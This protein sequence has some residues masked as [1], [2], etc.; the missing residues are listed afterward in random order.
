MNP[1]KYQEVW[2]ILAS[3]GYPPPWNTSINTIR[4]GIPKEN[5]FLRTTLRDII[6]PE[7][8][9]HHFLPK[10]CQISV[11]ITLGHHLQSRHQTRGL[12]SLMAA[13]WDIS[14][15]I[16]SVASCYF[17][18]LRHP[19]ASSGPSGADL[20]KYEDIEET[21]PFLF[22]CLIL[23]I[24]TPLIISVLST[25]GP[26]YTEPGLYGGLGPRPSAVFTTGARCFCRIL[27]LQIAVA[28]HSSHMIAAITEYDTIAERL[29][30]A[31]PS[32]RPPLMMPIVITMRPI[33]RWAYDHAVR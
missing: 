4:L 11:I 9:H 7:S 16:G 21:E 27:S 6:N 13:I 17:V 12:M 23:P 20:R 10:L 14:T 30:C 2:P 24:S 29:A 15:T 28:T 8:F 26:P 32:P 19:Q 22:T 31:S 25:G 1:A 33:Q 3:T 5:Q 18:C